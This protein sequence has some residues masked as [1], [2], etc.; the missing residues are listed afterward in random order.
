MALFP[1]FKQVSASAEDTGLKKQFVV[2]TD[3]K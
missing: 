1:F 3:T 2:A